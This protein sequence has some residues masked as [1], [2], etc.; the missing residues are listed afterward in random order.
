MIPLGAIQ[1]ARAAK[2]NKFEVVTNHRTFI[3]RA[4]N[5]GKH[6]NLQ[7][8]VLFF[9]KT[10]YTMQEFI[11]HFKHQLVAPFI[12]LLQ[13]YVKHDL[14]RNMHRD[15]F[16]VCSSFCRLHSQTLLHGALFSL[17]IVQRSKW[18]SVLQEWVKEQMVFGRPRFGPGSHCQ[19]NGFL[20]FKGIKS[21]IYAAII[22]EQI[23]LYKNEQV[24]Y[25]SLHFQYNFELS[26][27]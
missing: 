17:S 13:F 4:D 6:I 18:C 9:E 23:W 3:F 1:M 20:E 22:S 11:L 19:K 10:V 14:L 2:D 25:S 8:I 15:E 7:A 26:C 24:I 16:D 27:Q 21:K 5:E 12:P